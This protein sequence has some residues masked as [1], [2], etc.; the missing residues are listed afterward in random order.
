M[1][2]RPE[3]EEWGSGKG[4][5]SNSKERRGGSSVV[6]I[7]GGLQKTDRQLT[8]GEGVLRMLHGLCGVGRKGERLGKYY[9]TS[10]IL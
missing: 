1:I 3:G 9:Y 7:K 5:R 6:N 8:V 10:K 2:H 4:F